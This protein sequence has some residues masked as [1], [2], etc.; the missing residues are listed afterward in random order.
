LWDKRVGDETPDEFFKRMKTC[1]QILS[2]SAQSLYEGFNAGQQESA[3]QVLSRL[4]KFDKS[5]AHTQIVLRDSLAEIDGGSKIVEAM[6]REHLVRLTKSAQ[7]ADVQVEIVHDSL[8]SEWPVTWEILKEKERRNKTHWMIRTLSLLGIIVGIS[9]LFYFLIEARVARA[10]RA[11]RKKAA[12]IEW[13]AESGKE[14][15]D[16][17]SRIDLALML[18]LASYETDKY[19]P[20][21]QGA[22][23]DILHYSPRPKAFIKPETAMDGDVALNP[24]GQVLA[25]NDV[26][27]SIT[28]WDLTPPH[29]ELHRMADP[30]ARVAVKEGEDPPIT[31]LIFSADG[32]LLA[33]GTY[34]GPEAERI[35]AVAVWDVASGA[36]LATLIA[37]DKSAATLKAKDKKTTI[38]DDKESA[39]RITT[40]AFAPDG[41]SLAAG[42]V[43]GLTYRWETVD[44]SWD[45]ANGSAALVLHEDKKTTKYSI[46]DSDSVQ[47][48][49]TD[50]RFSPDGNWIA[51]G[52]T[53][54]T[55][56][57]WEARSGRLHR[58]LTYDCD[59]LKKKTGQQKQITGL[60]FA[61]QGSNLFVGSTEDVILYD[62]D[63]GQAIS[64]LN[65]D[66]NGVGM[67]LALSDDGKI[68][69][70][71]DWQ[72]GRYLWD[73]KGESIE[74][75]GKKTLFR[76]FVA[77]RSFAFSRDGNT[78]ALGGEN[79]FSAWN[80]A[81]QRPMLDHDDEVNGLAFSP[82]GRLLASA[83]EG[84]TV[85]LRDAA[86]HK[87]LR[88]LSNVG[89]SAA[90]GV[91]FSHSGQL[92]A[93][94][95]FTGSVTLW[96]LLDEQNESV[97]MEV[98]AELNE[99][100]GLERSVIVFT[101]DDKKI[102]TLSTYDDNGEEK[103]YLSTWDVG[104]QKLLNAPIKLPLDKA[105]KVTS[106][107]FSNDGQVLALATETE[108][109]SGSSVNFLGT[110]KGNTEI[111]VTLWNVTDGKRFDSLPTHFKS[112][113]KSLALNADGT[114]VAAGEDE[115]SRV[116]LWNR[117][118][119]SK[120]VVMPFEGHSGSISHL[121][122]NNDGTALSMSIDQ[123]DGNGDGESGLGESHKIFIWDIRLNTLG[124]L[125]T[126]ISS[127]QTSSPIILSQRGGDLS[128]HESST[129]ALAISPD[130][131]Q[132]AMADANHSLMIWDIVVSDAKK[133]ICGITNRKFTGEE[134]ERYKLE[135]YNAGFDPLNPCQ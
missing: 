84:G 113:V 72:G 78:I 14:L 109:G 69:Q 54:G 77:S 126:S 114:W 75:V 28:I 64:V 76:P 1:R 116:V 73:V 46:K 129:K 86:S 22:M 37:K 25:A 68:L 16:I 57:I 132:L 122:F 106:A 123:G 131:K 100:G 11:E 8:L 55:V 110:V 29:H 9:V 74:T 20:N 95:S 96:K 83:D 98:P 111:A 79:G 120:T 47:Y 13:A 65:S 97:L 43:Q 33:S 24:D 99:F 101:Q 32:R 45:K 23:L 26:D 121:A 62:A 56:M 66:L 48:S 39:D 53:Y 50:L 82:N 34:F 31:P 71:F 2:Q 63:G 3:R 90:F 4:I 125:I 94:Q 5:G 92:L 105:Q 51:S 115:E 85:T 49:I 119:D 107:T 12:V 40:I 58:A 15:A 134:V 88:Q 44:S 118:R 124:K 81:W 41:Q 6:E 70:G 36:R 30:D 10:Q 52:N 80:L 89:G 93:T 7:A 112:T 61:Q 128:E 127:K 103:V 38:S 104:E 18:A 35:A 60:A 135:R 130:G 17:D 21:A 102:I 19:S 42:S 27:G 91:A 133:F 59:C 108:E 67:Y 117:Q 87:L